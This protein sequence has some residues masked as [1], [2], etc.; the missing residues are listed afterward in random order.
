MDPIIAVLQIL[1][2]LYGGIGFYIIF[3]SSSID[4]EKGYV[5]TDAE[6][7]ADIVAKIKTRD[8]NF[9]SD[10]FKYCAR[11]CVLDI[12][13]HFNRCETQELM[14]LESTELFN[15][16]KSDIEQGITSKKLNCT[17]LE[18]VE[19]RKITKYKIDGNKEVIGCKAYFTY[20]NATIDPSSNSV[21]K[22]DVNMK[23]NT[24]YIEF[25][26]NK[27]VKHNFS[28]ALNQCPN[29]GALIE[30]NAQ[31]ICIYCDSSLINGEH[32]WVLNKVEPF[33]DKM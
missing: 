8:S 9:N 15:I 10:I 24:M 19:I 30:V 28:F 7:E 6:K 2:V 4:K 25:I 20:Q 13:D 23:K 12:Y 32:S 18:E 11:Q 14:P 5:Y 27:N 33:I 26:K 31:G 29:C 16:H 21:L 1:W 3:S 17:V 22:Y